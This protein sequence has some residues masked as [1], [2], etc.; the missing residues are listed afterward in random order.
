VNRIIGSLHLNEVVSQ[1]GNS[2][3]HIAILALIQHFNVLANVV[4]L[5][6]LTVRRKDEKDNNE[7]I[8]KMEQIQIVD[9]QGKREC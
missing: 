9:L 2:S 4:A 5:N 3:L 1:T 7:K 8:P 6:T